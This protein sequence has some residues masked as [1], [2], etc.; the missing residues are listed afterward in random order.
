MQE[1]IIYAVTDYN[2]LF[3]SKHNAAPYKS[4]MDKNKLAEH[5]KSLGYKLTF[6]HP[7]DISFSDDWANKPVIYTS[8]EDPGYI[9]KDFLEDII[10]SFE[11]KGANLI[12]SYKHLR[13]NNNK[14]FMH[15]LEEISLSDV[16]NI[17]PNKRFSTLSELK[18]FTDITYPVVIKLAT[19]AMSQNVELVKNYNELVKFVKNNSQSFSQWN[20]FKEFVRSFKYTGY[21][22]QDLIKNKYILQDFLPNL[23]SDYKIL[24]FDDYFYIFKR[25]VRDNDFRASGSG[26][27]NYLYGSSSD[28]PTGIFEL[29]DKIA[30]AIDTP[31][32]S[33]DIA[34]SN[35]ELYV[36]EYQSLYFG[37]VGQHRSDI[38]YTKIDNTYKP[39]INNF[40]LEELYARSIINYLESK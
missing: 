32:I 17:I 25:P 35:N 10:L 36:I 16:C 34:V 11:T 13:A 12:P 7:T 28:V 23:E 6:I 26:Q 14:A 20:R 27:H 29:V 39:S 40:E 3:G 31:T 15:M 19:G 33:V 8:Q 37:T 30:K 9:Y 38:V 21:K 2:G 5:F 1:K 18:S 22:K 24:K 4:G